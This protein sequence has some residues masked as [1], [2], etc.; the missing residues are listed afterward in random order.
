MRWSP[1]ERGW[2]PDR[3]LISLPREGTA[4][5]QW[6]M[7]Q[8]VGLTRRQSC[9]SL[10]FGLRSLRTVGN[11]FPLFMSSPGSGI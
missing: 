10:D 3:C 7:D 5:R 9:W 6:S 2:C 4:R 11:T 1:R 8:E